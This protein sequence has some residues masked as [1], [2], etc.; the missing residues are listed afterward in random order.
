M[1]ET[2]S[3]GKLPVPNT[4]R[5]ISSDMPNA[6]KGITGPSSN[7]RAADG[8]GGDCGRPGNRT[9]DS[10]FPSCYDPGRKGRAG[11][12]TPGFPRPAAVAIIPAS[13]Q[14]NPRQEADPC[15]PL[16]H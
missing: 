2:K 7:G 1:Y 10:Y 4:S 16:R 11:V 8:T 15:R 12:R 9:A 3:V 5:K 14:E 13:D 6:K